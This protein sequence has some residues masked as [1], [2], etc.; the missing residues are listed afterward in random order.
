MIFK[1]CGIIIKI[2]SVFLSMLFIAIAACPG[3]AQQGTSPKFSYLR[4]FDFKDTMS[5]KL[6]G[7][8]RV[9]EHDKR[10]GLN[11]TSIHSVL[12]MK[13]HTLK[14]NEGI[15]SLWV[16]PL[17]DLSPY[18]D[19]ERMGM[20]NPNY[21][22]YPFLSDYP[23]PQEEKNSNF[24]FLWSTSWHPSIR[25]QFGKGNFYEDNFDYPHVASVSVSHFTVHAKKWYQFTLTWNYSKDRYSL[26]ANGILIGRED[27][28]RENKLRRDSVNPSLY[29]GNP[30]LCYS[31]IRF[32]DRELS[33]KDIYDG[34]RQ[35]SSHFDPELEK[36]LRYTYAGK[37]RKKFDFQS[38]P[39]CV[40]KLSLT[41]QSPSERDSF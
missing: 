37:G 34:F 35:Q 32:F 19:R 30:T 29:I 14:N 2:K 25:V 9:I 28:F 17:E 3:Y 22:I 40:K 10:Q 11:L 16:M 6:T 8:A 18:R 41:L 1:K 7:P 31:D 15:V 33:A 4:D 36:E 23:T 38:G 26:Y 13:A 39:G 27:Q 21:R 24:K 5:A 12:Q 20:N